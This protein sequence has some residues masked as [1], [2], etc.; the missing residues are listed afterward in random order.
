LGHL[1]IYTGADVPA[2]FAQSAAQCQ[3]FHQ[4]VQDSWQTCN[5]E[6]AAVMNRVKAVEYDSYEGPKQ[7]LKAYMINLEAR[8]KAVIRS[9]QGL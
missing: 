6:L 8:I 3:Q 2:Y 4:L 9:Q 5:G 7:T 1:A